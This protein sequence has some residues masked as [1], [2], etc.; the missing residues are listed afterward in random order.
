MI[1]H[2]YKSVIFHNNDLINCDQNINEIEEQAVN[3]KLLLV[4][5]LA[6]P[7]FRTNH[8]FHLLASNKMIYLLRIIILNGCLR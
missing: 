4:N 2:V 8:K 3:F 5:Y 7:L 1:F 6:N